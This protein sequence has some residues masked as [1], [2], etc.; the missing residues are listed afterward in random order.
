MDTTRNERGRLL[1]W[2]FGFIL[3]LGLLLLVL[4]VQYSLKASG[5]GQRS[6]RSAFLRWRPQIL[7]LAQGV[8]VYTLYN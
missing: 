5:D 2:Q 4:S 1:F 8:D 7:E 3:G 6:N